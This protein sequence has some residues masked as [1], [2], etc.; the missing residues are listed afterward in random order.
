MAL[1]PSYQFKTL[2][3]IYTFVANE[4]KVQIASTEDINRIKRA[5]N[6]TYL[7]RVAQHTYWPWLRRTIDLPFR[8]RQTFQG[9]LTQNST[10]VTLTT[11]PLQSVAG[12]LLSAQGQAQ[13]LKIATHT[14]NTATLELESPYTPPPSATPGATTVYIWSE[15]VIL[16]TDCRQVVSVTHNTLNK[17]LELIGMGKYRQLVTASPALAY[18]PMYF[19]IFDYIDPLPF[20]PVGGMPSLVTSSS[21]GVIR[22][23]TFAS[24][25]STS[26]IQGQ[27]IN[28]Q[29]SRDYRFNGN[30]VVSSVGGSVLTYTGRERIELSAAADSGLIFQTAAVDST[31]ERYQ[32]LFL[33]PNQLTVDKTV[34]VEY[35]MDLA[36]LIEDTDEPL[37]PLGDRVAI[38]YGALSLVW[39]SIGRN[40]EE[41][42]R[43]EGMFTSKLSSMASRIDSATD[44]PSM[45]PDKIYLQRK[46]SPRSSRYYYWD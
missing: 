42:Q 37:M 9:T 40:P 35:I 30:Y 45:I 25:I 21:T 8:A 32:E 1:T 27:R 23:L 24:D 29:G 4:L 6:T 7:D 17:P 46:R 39:S 44:Y 16:P 19:A 38:A 14:A 10:T 15:S 2:E 22:T 36:P 28:I 34:T 5:I 26:V 43:N 11:A 18:D 33:Y 31:D 41:S 3:D 13:R 12:Y 20:Q